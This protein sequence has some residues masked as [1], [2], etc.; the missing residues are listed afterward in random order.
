MISDQIDWDSV[1][2]KV[3][4][5]PSR[6]LD[7]LLMKSG[8]VHLRKEEFLRREQQRVRDMIGT[9]VMNPDVADPA[10]PSAGIRTLGW[11]RSLAAAR[12]CRR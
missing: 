4:R 2:P 7:F 8:V 6:R 1:D 11:Q 12:F 5:P 9:R 10:S 3:H